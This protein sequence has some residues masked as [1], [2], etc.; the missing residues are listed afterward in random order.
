MKIRNNPVNTRLSVCLRYI[1][2]LKLVHWLLLLLM[3]TCFQLYLNRETMLVFAWTKTALRNSIIQWYHPNS[4]NSGKWKVTVSGIWFVQAR[5][6][7]YSSRKRHFQ[8]SGVLTLLPIPQEIDKAEELSPK[9]VIS[10]KFCFLACKKAE[11]LMPSRKTTD[12]NHCLIV[13]E[14]DSF[15]QHLNKS[16]VILYNITTS[17]SW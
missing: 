17:A 8:S 10:C 1:W 7:F 9:S 13:F 6:P 4:E 16:F 5:L 14:A 3:E 12:K 2:M 15:S 11:G